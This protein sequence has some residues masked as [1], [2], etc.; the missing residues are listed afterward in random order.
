MQVLVLL[1]RKLE[2]YS[3]LENCLQQARAKAIT[4]EEQHL[5]K[6]K[7]EFPLCNNNAIM[8]QS[9]LAS[10]HLNESLLK[11]Q[12]LLSLSDCIP[13]PPPTVNIPNLSF[14]GTRCFK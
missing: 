4:E 12:G 8:K 13:A 14:N 6:M 3:Q 2:I 5:S 1:K 9:F 7:D 11:E 10:S